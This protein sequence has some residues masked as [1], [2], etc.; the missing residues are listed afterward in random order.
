MKPSEPSE[1]WTVASVEWARHEPSSTARERLAADRTL[2]R[3]KPPSGPSQTCRLTP[4]WSSS[5]GSSSSVHM[6]SGSP[7]PTLA[8]HAPSSSPRSTHARNA[9]MIRSRNPNP[10]PPPLKGC[11]CPLRGS[12]PGISL[13]QHCAHEQHVSL[14]RIP[15]L[16][17]A[18]IVA[19][20]GATSHMLG[21]SCKTLRAERWADTSCGA[22]S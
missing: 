2:L 14:A 10:S 5:P 6:I 19:A 3:S 9:A 13:Q 15:P 16:S 17:A 18:P 8:S 12:A 22:G 21:L 4:S 20:L 1:S 11:I 7:S